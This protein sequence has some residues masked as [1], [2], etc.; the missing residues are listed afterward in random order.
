MLMPPKDFKAWRSKLDK[1]KQVVRR[2]NPSEIQLQQSQFVM[3]KRVPAGRST[4]VGQNSTIN[5]IQSQ[6]FNLQVDESLVSM[7]NAVSSDQMPMSPQLQSTQIISPD[8]DGSEEINSNEMAVDHEEA[9]K[10][11][12]KQVEEH[13]DDHDDG[14]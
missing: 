13:T 12:L 8:T 2:A 1:L 6:C 5:Q 11:E 3:S 4:S 14:D 9:K 10:E 7:E